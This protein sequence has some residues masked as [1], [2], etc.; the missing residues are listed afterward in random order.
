ES[1]IIDALESGFSNLGSLLEKQDALSE[2]NTSLIRSEISM[3]AGSVNST[4]GLAVGGLANQMG[5]MQGGIMQTLYSDTTP[6][7]KLVK[8]N[9]ASIAGLSTQLSNVQNAINNIEAGSGDNT[10][11]MSAISSL[12]GDVSGLSDDIG[13]LSGTVDGLSTALGDGFEG[14]NTELQG[15]GDGIDSIVG[16]LNGDGLS[17]RGSEGKID[18]N[19][20]G[21]YGEDT[22]TE[23]KAEIE[24]LK[25]EYSEQM[26]AMQGLFS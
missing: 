6:T 5:S 7:A 16:T 9:A 10:E 3:S 11:V 22:L 4:I 19:G 24:T 2:S 14:I 1:S 8:D 20:T 26:K 21:L 12:S 17:T 25:T 18:F 13:T 15:I 23:M